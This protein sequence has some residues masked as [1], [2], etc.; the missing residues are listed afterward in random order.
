MY[1]RQGLTGY[2]KQQNKATRDPPGRGA[3]HG[4]QTQGPPGCAGN[5]LHLEGD[6]DKV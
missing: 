1:R 6:G 5:S 3:E 2:Q 4:V